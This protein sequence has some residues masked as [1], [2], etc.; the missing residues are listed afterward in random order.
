MG[1][2][3]ATCTLINVVRSSKLALL[4]VALF[5]SRN[6]YQGYGEIAKIKCDCHSGLRGN[7]YNQKPFP[8][9]SSLGLRC[10][11]I[12]EKHNSIAVAIITKRLSKHLIPRGRK[13]AAWVSFIDKKGSS[14]VSRSQLSTCSNAQMPIPQSNHLKSGWGLMALL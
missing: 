6:I 12:A 10:N 8:R 9:I 5:T 7:F 4:L 3:A 11:F 14:L 1:T 13:M 2:N